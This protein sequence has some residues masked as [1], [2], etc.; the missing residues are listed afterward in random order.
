MFSAA[1]PDNAW[2]LIS[3]AVRSA[4]RKGMEW[5]AN[6]MNALKPMEWTSNQMS[7]LKPTMRTTLPRVPGTM[8][9]PNGTLGGVI[10]LSVEQEDVQRTE[11]PSL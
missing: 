1:L 3:P 5:I 11:P 2:A 8:A 10:R 9:T 4:Y 6:Q 7:P